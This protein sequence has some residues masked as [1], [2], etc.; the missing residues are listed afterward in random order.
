MCFN[1]LLKN[2][3]SSC[4]GNIV[5]SSRYRY[6]TLT[7]SFCTCS[8]SC[9]A[10]HLSSAASAD[11]GCPTLRPPTLAGADLFRLDGAAQEDD[12]G[13][14][15]RLCRSIFSSWR[16]LDMLL[17]M[18]GKNVCV[19]T[20]ALGGGPKGTSYIRITFAYFRCGSHLVSVL[21][22]STYTLF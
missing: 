18:K 14:G 2:D 22:Q 21:K 8:N 13:A 9:E 19:C 1:F 7:R 10:V 20:I 6:G 16:R 4:T 15:W 11:L 5:V 12:D 3:L 17:Q